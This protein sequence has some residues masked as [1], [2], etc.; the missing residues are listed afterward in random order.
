MIILFWIFY[1]QIT[2]ELKYSWKMKG[3]R[4]I[5]SCNGGQQDV[6]IVSGMDG[7]SVPHSW[8]CFPQIG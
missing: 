1:V 4:G 2:E 5:G 6:G 8:H 3:G 7:S